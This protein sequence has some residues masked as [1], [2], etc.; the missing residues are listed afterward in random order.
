MFQ[1]K[2]RKEKKE[3]YKTRSGVILQ[4]QHLGGGGRILSLRKPGLQSKTLKI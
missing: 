2:K 1:L 3:V 4:F